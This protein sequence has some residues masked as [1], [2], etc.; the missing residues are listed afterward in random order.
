MLIVSLLFCHLHQLVDDCLVIAHFLCFQEIFC[1]G[2]FFILGQFHFSSQ[3]IQGSAGST[4]NKYLVNICH[5]AGV[6]A[7]HEIH[8]GTTFIQ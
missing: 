3:H 1:G 5:G 8:I 2:F 7:H 6:L 4:F